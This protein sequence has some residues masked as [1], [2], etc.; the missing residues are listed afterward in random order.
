MVIN[1]EAIQLVCWRVNDIDY[2]MMEVR[3]HEIIDLRAR[4][5]DLLGI[6]RVFAYVDDDVEWWP[7]TKI[8]SFEVWAA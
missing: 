8:G 4:F 5:P 2:P 7:Q 3:P 6:P 1:R